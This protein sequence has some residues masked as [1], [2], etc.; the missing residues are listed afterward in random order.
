[1][2]PGIEQSKPVTAPGVPENY[3]D[4]ERLVT[5]DWIRPKVLV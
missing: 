3:P 2:T 1:M 5:E 4:A